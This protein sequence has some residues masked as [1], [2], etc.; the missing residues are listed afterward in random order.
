MVSN[1]AIREFAESLG[2]AGV[3]DAKRQKALAAILPEKARNAAFGVQLDRAF[4][5]IKTLEYNARARGYREAEMKIVE[6]AVDAFISCAKMNADRLQNKEVSALNEQLNELENQFT[7]ISYEEGESIM[8]IRENAQEIVRVY[9]EGL[10]ALEADTR[11]EKANVEKLKKAGSYIAEI[12]ASLDSVADGSSD[13]AAKLERQMCDAMATWA[14]EFA[15]GNFAESA[16][17]ELAKAAAT[18]KSW[19][20]LKAPV[21][22]TGGG[23]FGFLNKGAKEAEEGSYVTYEEAIKNENHRRMLVLAKYPEARSKIEALAGLIAN[24]RSSVDTTGQMAMQQTLD[25]LKEEKARLEAELDAVSLRYELS[26]QGGAEGDFLLAQQL[27]DLDYQLSDLDLQI[28]D[29]QISLSAQNRGLLANESN[30]RL[31]EQTYHILQTQ[32]NNKPNLVSLAGCIN[33]A[34]LNKI[35]ENTAS[36]QD[37]MEFVN[38]DAL[39]KTA[40]TMGTETNAAI[41][42][43]RA[44]VRGITHEGTIRTAQTQGQDTARVQREQQA[45]SR[46]QEIL[47]RRRRTAR[48]EQQTEAQETQTT[49]AISLDGLALGNDT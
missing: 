34:V 28:E 3:I 47:N 11:G 20:S 22:K 19:A 37:M 17:N 44:E 43:L 15:N 5:R 1:A 32:L 38:M 25:M 35:L 13:N 26:C 27:E 48:P 39:A 41:R 7:M 12:A 4:E 29:Y 42:N 2:R 36:E 16:L 8:N 21:F 49:G 10:P 18:A 45:N 46:A 14:H 30:I 9:Q 6:G 24:T 40:N 31:L 23:I 33:F